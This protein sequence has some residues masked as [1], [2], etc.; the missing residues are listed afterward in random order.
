MIGDPPPGSNRTTNPAVAGGDDV[1]GAPS[2]LTPPAVVS[3][4]AGSPLSWLRLARSPAQ[5]QLLLIVLLLL[6]LVARWPWLLAVSASLAVV[7]S[8]SLLLPPLWRLLSRQLEDLTTARTLAVLTLL[9]STVALSLVLGW[10]QPLIQ[11]FQA[12]NWE[13]IGAIGEGVIGAIGQILVALVALLIAWRQVLVDQRLSGQQNRITQA[14]TI[15]SFIQGVTELVVDEEGLLEDWPLERMLVEGR[16]AAVLGSVD[17]DG[18]ARILRFLSHARLLTPLLRDQRLG[19]AILDGQGNYQADRLQ[20]VPVI[21]L[22]AMLQGADLSGTDLRGVDF[23][24]ADLRGCRF[25]HCDLSG[26]NLA[27]CNLDAADLRHTLLADTQ[28]FY[29]RPHTA[30]PASWNHS[31]AGRP[32]FVGY[33][34]QGSEDGT[35]ARVEQADLAGARGLSA[36]AHYYLASWGGSRTRASLP[37]GCRAIPNRLGAAGSARPQP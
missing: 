9:L 7:L 12:G 30:T 4:P 3:A 34:P 11:L 6:A 18:K 36:S 8:C 33:A 21:Q 24:G 5:Q 23:N 25:H 28:F 2:P 29:G 20:G 10:W 26:A 32:P 37:G 16:L 17:A 13:A 27:A 31:P 22:G 15:D 19:R 35:G 1:E 14:Q